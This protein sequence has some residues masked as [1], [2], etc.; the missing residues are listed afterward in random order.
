MYVFIQ[1]WFAIV[2]TGG[3]TMRDYLRD[4][5]RREGVKGENICYFCFLYHGC[6][7]AKGRVIIAELRGAENGLNVEI[8]VIC[9][10]CIMMVWL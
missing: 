9:D 3:E 4:T 1:S 2:A 7:G 5:Q 10:F 8:S 6:P